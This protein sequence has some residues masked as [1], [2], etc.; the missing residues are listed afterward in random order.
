MEVDRYKIEL[1]EGDEWGPVECSLGVY[2]KGGVLEYVDTDDLK[3]RNPTVCDEEEIQNRIY[4]ER[5]SP[6]H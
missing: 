1:V 5:V 6:G 3:N 2:G 4:S